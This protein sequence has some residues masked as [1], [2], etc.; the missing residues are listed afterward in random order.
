M[1]FYKNAGAPR[2]HDQRFTFTE[3]E[4]PELLRRNLLLNHGVVHRIVCR[5][6]V[7]TRNKFQPRNRADHDG[8]ALLGNDTARLD[9]QAESR[10]LVVGAALSGKRLAQSLATPARTVRH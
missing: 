4:I 8:P 3:T 7:S 9:A 1:S 10:V 2:C 6:V 5:L